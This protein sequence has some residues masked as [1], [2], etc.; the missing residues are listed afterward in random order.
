V[1]ASPKKT[2]RP[3]DEWLVDESDAD[4]PPDPEGGGVGAETAQWL[5]EPA[6]EVNGAK[7]TA[8]PPPAAEEEKAPPPEDSFEVTEP[9]EPKPR[10]SAS[11]RSSRAVAKSDQAVKELKTENR[12]LAKRIRE[13]QAELR[14]YAKQAKAETAKALK[15]REA[16][17]MKRFEER[18]EKLR[19]RIDQ[20]ESALAEAQKVQKEGKAKAEPSKPRKRRAAKKQGALDLNRASFEDLRNL[21]L[22]VTQSARVIAYRDTRGGYESLDELDE[23]P[24]LPKGMRSSLRRQVTLSS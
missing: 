3:A 14:S 13:L 22:S 7:E 2:Q 17:L 18:E 15:D 10:R 12:E 19:E 1:A 11:R 24:G 21:G 9:S 16:D 6:T 8:P 20:A 5:V 23:I 4:A